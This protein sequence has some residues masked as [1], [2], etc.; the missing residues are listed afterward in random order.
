MAT[1]QVKSVPLTIGSNTVT[2]D[3]ATADTN[4]AVLYRCFNSSTM[5][6]VPCVIDPANY[7]TTGFTAV[8]AVAGTL[9]YMVSEYTSAV[10]VTVPSSLMIVNTVDITPP[11]QVV[12]FGRTVPSTGYVLLFR[13]YDPD[14]MDTIGCEVDESSYTLTGFTAEAASP[15]TLEY[16]VM[17]STD[18]G[19]PLSRSWDSIR[20]WAEAIRDSRLTG[21]QFDHFERMILVHRAVTLTVSVLY[22]LLATKYLTAETVTPVDD[23]IDISGIRAMFRG[24]PEVRFM[25]ESTSAGCIVATSKE[26]HHRF[27]TS[28]SQN[29][30]TIAW[31]LVGDSIYVKKGS[32]LS[33]YGTLTLWYP[34]QP[35]E[36]TV[37]T[38]LLDI[39]DGIP[40]EIALL[41][42]K[43]ILAERYNVKFSGEREME[44]LI[45]KFYSTLGVATNLEEVKDKTAKLL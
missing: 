39:P 10:S 26:E 29:S 44:S 31:S 45:Q 28:A 33:S 32:G 42:L 23:V 1:L 3:T 15:C 21:V 41:K 37:A 16:A 22:P 34:R 20:M 35:L 24:G 38:T 43:M 27:R 14:T 4:Y 9:E 6:T 36:P 17:L 12:S 7:L 2:F 19:L 11:S 40:M 30:D 5:A 8:A 13:A 25:L 18:S